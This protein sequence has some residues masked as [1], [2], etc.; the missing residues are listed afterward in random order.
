MRIGAAL[1]VGH[2]LDGRSREWIDRGE[3]ADEDGRGVD[4]GE[5]DD[6]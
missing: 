6:C 2:V 5:V 1:R 4:G 3:R